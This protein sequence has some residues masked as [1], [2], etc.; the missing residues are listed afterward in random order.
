MSG[1]NILHLEDNPTDG[2][3]IQSVLQAAGIS[4][5]IERVETQAD[6]VA[7]LEQK[8]FDLILSDY[9]LPSFDGASALELARQKSPDVP[10]IFVSGTIG[11]EVAVDSLKQGASDYVLKDRLSRLVTSVQ[12]AI[13]E[14]QERA[15]RRQAELKVREQAALLD[16]ATD[17]IFARDLEQRITYWN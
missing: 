9:T 17:A 13:R 10:F 16:Q 15:E 11:E 3:L 7:G 1:L 4:F 8:R 6:F 2:E 14:A 12:R 5:V